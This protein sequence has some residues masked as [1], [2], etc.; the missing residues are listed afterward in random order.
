M[1]SYQFN[2][3]KAP[4][5]AHDGPVP[6]P[7]AKEVVVEVKAAGICG[8]D[9]HVRNGVMVTSKTPITLGHEIAGIVAERG[10]DVTQVDEGDSVV[11]DYV[12]S[13]GR[14][15]YCGLGKDNLCLNGMAIGFDL[16]GGFSDHVVVPA[17]NVVR[18]PHGLPFEQGA[19]IGCAV[20]TSFHATKI[21]EVSLGDDVAVFG[22]GGVGMHAVQWARLRGAKNII[23]VDVAR[24]KLEL[25][26]EFGATHVLDPI[27]EDAARTISEI[28]G[29]KGVEAAM[30]FAGQP[31]SLN[32]AINSVA[33]GGRIVVIGR[34]PREIPIS[35]WTFLRRE[36]QMRTSSDHLRNEIPAIVEQVGR[37]TVDLSKSISLKLPLDKIN[38]GLDAL[39]NH[40]AEYLRIAVTP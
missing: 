8:S 16:D 22:L 4:L 34:G 35:P 5:V 12:I 3:V 9:V 30:D 36:L 37:G 7:G 24:K 21:A 27:S 38:D 6:K 14:C 15:R 17:E 33:R 26:K 23:G 10:T 29:E 28:T 1:R 2:T 32:G 20:A 39:E 11:A 19:I 18:L 13:C 31:A 25:A 40:G